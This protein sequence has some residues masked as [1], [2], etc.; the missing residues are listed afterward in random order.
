MRRAHVGSL[1]VAVCLVVPAQAQAQEQRASIEGTVRDGSGGV[2]PGARVQATS[3]SGVDVATSTD[4][5]G[6]YRFPSIASGEYEIVVD[7]PGF[8][9]SRVAAIELL[10]GQNLRVDLTLSAAPLAETIAVVAD[11]PTIDVT[12]SGRVTT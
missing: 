7:H 11:A 4:A 2:V 8:A 5:T 10:L 9:P 12:Q 1:I 3:T 6:H